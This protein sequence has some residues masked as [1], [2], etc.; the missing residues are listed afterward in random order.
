MLTLRRAEDRGHANFG[1]LDTHHSFSFGQ[2]YDPDHMGF[3]PLR[4]IN[5]DR[6]SGGQGFPTHPHRNMEIVTYVLDG[7]LRHQDSIGTGSVIRAGD[8]QV[9]SAG[10]GI[11]HSE[12]NASS[13]DPVHLLQ[14]WLL[15]EQEGLTPRY[16]Q[17]TFSREDKRG[18][19]RL[20][21]SPGG[22]DGSLTVHSDADTYAAVLEDGDVVHHTLKPGRIG[23]LQV[24]RGQATVNDL[25][26]NSGDGAAIRD[27]GP[28]RI[29]GAGEGAEL[30]L[31]DM[32]P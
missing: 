10:R 25:A 22:R 7:A 12:Y 30:L 11:R 4:V 32:G 1:W 2:Y 5:D 21:G 19:L 17:K 23:W 20:I 16:D 29:A 9:M 24:A 6:I 13:N 15:P 27:G 28:M 31:F 26:L 8:V 14:I 18:Q 3:G